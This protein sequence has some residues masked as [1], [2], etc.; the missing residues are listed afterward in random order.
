MTKR[1]TRKDVAPG[2]KAIDDHLR[3]MGVTRRYLAAKL[4]ISE[5]AL[6]GWWV[7]NKLPLDRLGEL[8]E[9][10]G[11]DPGDV[12]PDLAA[13]FRAGYAREVPVTVTK[14]DPRS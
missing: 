2:L 6:A 1:R 3:Q 5:Q 14:P 13:L 11:I 7:R 8:V 12:A 9:I 4:D 10:L